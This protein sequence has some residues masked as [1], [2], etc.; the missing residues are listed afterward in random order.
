MK[1]FFYALKDRQLGVFDKP[2]VIDKAKDDM[3]EGYRRLIVSDPDKSF[4]L[5][6]ATLFYYGY[7]DDMTGKFEML[8]DPEYLGD[9]GDFFPVKE[10]KKDA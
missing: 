5:K 3:L 4:Q 10:G 2:M 6:P 8:K 1:L 7:F 9:L